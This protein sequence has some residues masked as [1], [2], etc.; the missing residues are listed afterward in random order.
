MCPMRAMLSV[1][2]PTPTSH[3][4]HCLS[5]CIG[6]KPVIDEIY[7]I[8]FIKLKKNYLTTKI[9]IILI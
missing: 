1:D 5:E 4:L 8:K 9:K 7:L 6:C 3:S 2:T